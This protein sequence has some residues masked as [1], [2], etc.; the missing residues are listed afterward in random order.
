[1]CEILGVKGVGGGK[2]REWW[3]LRGG[4]SLICR[5]KME[6]LKEGECLSCGICR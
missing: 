1:M 4:E 5:D 3:H 6:V 2:C